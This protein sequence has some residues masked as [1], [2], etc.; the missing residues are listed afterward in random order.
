MADREMLLP[1]QKRVKAKQEEMK[2]RPKQRNAATE[3][4][5]AHGLPRHLVATLME[6]KLLTYSGDSV[7]D[8]AILHFIAS[9]R[10]NRKFARFIM[11]AFS[12]SELENIFSTKGMDDLDVII[13]GILQAS[14]YIS[15]ESVLATLEQSRGIPGSKMIRDKIKRLRKCVQN[16]RSYEKN[17]E[18]FGID[19][20]ALEHARYMAERNNG[21]TKEK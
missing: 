12:R 15:T 20:L 11:S 14:K 7:E 3:V 18:D 13:Y 8:V 21:K 1:A 4:S 6:M 10:R 17:K 16:Q 2:G 19:K 5:K 9:I